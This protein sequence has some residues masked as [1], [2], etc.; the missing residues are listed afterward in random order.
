MA[1]LLNTFNFEGRAPIRTVIAGGE[2]LWVAKDVAEALGYRWAGIASI[3]HVPSEW[4]GINSV[5]TPSGVQDMATLSEQGLY[6]FLGRS[7]KPAALPFQKWIAGEVLPAIRKTG[8]YAVPLQPRQ[9]LYQVA[10]MELTLPRT[11]T[12]ALRTMALLSDKAE[13]QHHQIQT[14]Q[15]KAAF[16]DAVAM[17][18]G[19][20][21]IGAVARVLGTGQNRF[22][23]WMRKARILL[24]N[25]LPFQEFIDRGYFR[26]IEQTWEG[27]SGPH[28]SPKTL[29]TAKGLPWLQKRWAERDAPRKPRPTVN[30]DEAAE[31]LGVSREIASNLLTKGWAKGPD[32]LLPVV[33]IPEPRWDKAHI[34]KLWGQVPEPDQIYYRTFTT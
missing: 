12:E 32:G 22:F 20:Q 18:E 34:L 23:E 10:G 30:T 31:L 33:Q 15:P 13:E 11:F 24:P 7:D 1:D 27:N 2:P 29:I 16:H 26:V 5:L 3:N 8:A 6:F 28:V 19:A 25:N 4:R 14:L 9:D 17:A 21:S